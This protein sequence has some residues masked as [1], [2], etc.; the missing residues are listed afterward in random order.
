LR[1]PFHP[2]VY[3]F[4]FHQ[5]VSTLPLGGYNLS[6]TL[7]YYNISHIISISDTMLYIPYHPIQS[8]G[9]WLICFQ[10]NPASR[11]MPVSPGSSR[12]GDQGRLTDVCSTGIWWVFHVDTQIYTVKGLWD[13]TK[14]LD[15]PWYGIWLMVD[16]PLWK[17]WKSVGMIIPS[18]WKK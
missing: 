7:E 4:I 13:M 18:I 10:S 12:Y 14:Q 15:I 2:L 16:L 9:H 3:H 1:T 5:H 6:D 11:T 8:H 17:I